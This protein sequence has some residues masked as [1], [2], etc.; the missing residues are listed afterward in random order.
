[1]ATRGEPRPP[2]WLAVAMLAAAVGLAATIGFAASQT[3]PATNSVCN[4]TFPVRNGGY[5]TW[6]YVFTAIGAFALGH[7]VSQWGIARRG[8][9]QTALGEGR[10]SNRKAV[11]GVN[12]GVAIF[13][14]VVTG[15]L[16]FEAYTIAHGVWPITYYVRCANDAGPLVS[17]GG[18]ALY[19]FV[20]GRWMWV[21]ED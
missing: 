19:S 15:L 9:S 6:L 11:V 20:V 14:F 1:M 10:W 12:I 2:T 16:L 5:Q 17:L 21:L 13:L 8:L 18:A 3:L 7:L 4:P